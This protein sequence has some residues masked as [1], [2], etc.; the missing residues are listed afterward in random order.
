MTPESERKYSRRQILEAGKDA[1][2]LLFTFF[3]GL[4][5]GKNVTISEL[6]DVVNYQKDQASRISDDA[7]NYTTKLEK[8]DEKLKAL[9]PSIVIRAYIPGKEDPCCTLGFYDITTSMIA[10]NDAFLDRI[11]EAVKLLIPPSYLGLQNI[12]L[13]IQDIKLI[14]KPRKPISLVDQ[15][16]LNIFEYPERTN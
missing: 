13:V 10:E 4:E 9:I 5:G 2:P 6:R 15:K 11:T 16:T 8:Y 14:D 12:D 1:L 3:V 7:L